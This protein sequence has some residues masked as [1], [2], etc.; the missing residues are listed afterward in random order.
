M[1]QSCATGGFDIILDG[2]NNKNQNEKHQNDWPD[3]KKLCRLSRSN[4]PDKSDQKY[5]FYHWN[6]SVSSKMFNETQKTLID[7]CESAN[8][9]GATEVDIANI[10]NDNKF[11]RHQVHYMKKLGKQV[12]GLSG[13]EN[14]SDKDS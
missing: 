7:L 8:A 14:V 6:T 5:N 2:T 13:E 11:T 10:E 12:K 3:G 4:R 9:L 1:S